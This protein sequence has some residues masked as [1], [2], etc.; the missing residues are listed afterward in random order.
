MAF[1]KI[2]KGNSSRI[3]FSHTPFSE[4]TVY[5]TED[6]GGVYL[7]TVS[8]GKQA[9]K[10]L[11]TGSSGVGVNVIDMTLLASTWENNSQT[12]TVDGVSETSNGIVGLAQNM[13]NDTLEAAKAAGLTL[14]EQSD[15]TM[16][17]SA[18]GVV[19]TC[20]IPVVLVLYS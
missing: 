4:G 10:K 17:F 5:Y 18:S 6:D 9:R 7:D 14:V 16:S 13:D 1:F 20:D 2:L 15:N 19:P 3:S 12:V 11:N 8:N